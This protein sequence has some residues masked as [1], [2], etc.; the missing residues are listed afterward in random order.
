MA[1]LRRVA[2]LAALVLAVPVLAQTAS[3][4]AATVADALRQTEGI[5]RELGSAQVSATDLE[6]LDT[7]LQALRHSAEGCIDSQNGAA[8]MLEKNLGLLG[9][10]TPAEDAAVAKA[11]RDMEKV[12]QRVDQ[13]LASCRLLLV[14]SDALTERLRGR[15][16]KAQAQRLLA[17][18]PGLTA[19]SQSLRGLPDAADILRTHWRDMRLGLA[20]PG[21]AGLGLLALLLA[22]ALLAG[23]R[24]R[25][26]LR[27]S[28]VAFPAE[29]IATALLQALTA[30]AAHDAI[31]LL[32]VLVWAGFWSIC[33]WM[34]ISTASMAVLSV[35]LASWLS[36]AL[37]SRGLF[38]PPPPAVPPLPC[39]QQASRRLDRALCTA[40]AL[41]SAGIAIR[42]LARDTVLPAGLGDLAQTLYLVLLGAVTML[43]SWRFLDLR[44]WPG[45]GLLRLLLSAVIAAAVG[46][47]LLGYRGLGPYLL[48]ALLLSV[49]IA[50]GAWL[51]AR[52]VGDFFDGLDKGHH[53]WQRALQGR[54][55]AEEDRDRLPG[56]LWLRLLTALAVWTGAGLLLLPVWAVPD[57]VRSLLA[58]WL[59][60]G[61]AIGGLRL[62]PLRVVVALAVLG[63]LL[64]AVAVLK[65]RV[66]TRWLRRTHLE[67]GTRNAFATLLGY[68]G[69]ALAVLTA[70]AVAGVDLSKLALIA[71]A[72]SVGIGFGLQNVVNNFVSGLIL[73]FERPIRR[74]DWIVVGGTEGRV[75]HVSIRSTKIRTFDR[76]DVVVPNSELISGQVTNWTLRDLTGRVRVPVG[77]AY[78]SNL[79]LV[80]EI[81]LGIAA[82]QPLA[83]I[84]PSAPAPAVLFLGFGDSALNLELRFFVRDVNRRLTVLSEVNFAIDATFREAGIEIPFPQRDLHLRTGVAPADREGSPRPERGDHQAAGTDSGA[85]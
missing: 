54:L 7:R 17:R 51:L 14:R 45:R 28:A 29:S 62:S 64:S 36:L 78:G 83:L 30:A 73:L 20:A 9:K 77:V 43:V 4:D 82:A 61:I 3:N 50:A 49:L 6:S 52:L 72:L 42:F 41:V 33:A 31:V 85:E 48:H 13:T 27:A 63:L 1:A 53:G 2:W 76:S 32:P 46:A 12:R 38:A 5:D 71:G 58:G 47:E 24:L 80:R 39:E 69:G 44:S 25:R 18:G 67:E 19:L 35:A 37:V 81:L 8:D 16:D 11:R 22:A 68:G 65:Q 55:G 74:G 15:L 59:T 10:P 57:S 60:G 75:H 66:E 26:R 79:D 23:L 56:S 70:L 21:A 84:E 40:A 34:G